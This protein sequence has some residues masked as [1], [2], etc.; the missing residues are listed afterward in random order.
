MVRLSL[1]A[2]LALAALP[3]TVTAQA[4]ERT[5]R[6]GLEAYER[7]QWEL[8]IQEFE[9]ILKTG[10]RSHALYYNLGNAYYR[11]KDVA[12]AVWAYELALKLRPRDADSRY[13]LAL[14]GLRVIDR[15][16]EPELPFYVGFYRSLRG[17]LTPRQWVQRISWLL[18]ASAFLFATGQQLEWRRSRGLAGL[19]MG[20]ALLLSLLAADSIYTASTTREGIIYSDPSVAYSAPSVRS[21]ALF[22]LHA[23]AKVAIT[24]A[25]NRWLQVELL[26]GKSGW[27]PEEQLRPL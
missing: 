23:G 3:R 7:G 8:S 5:Y 19:G 10:Y 20:L 17:S 13:N 9:A 16:A 15:L 26:D 12:G 11:A 1:L 21:T 4:L 6:Q 14:G 27:I 24:G 2:L 18:L 22:E 25:G